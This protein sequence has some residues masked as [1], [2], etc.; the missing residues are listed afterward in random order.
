MKQKHLNTTIEEQVIRKSKFQ[1]KKI[2]D[3]VQ[4]NYKMFLPQLCEE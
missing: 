4:D 1:S 3:S 2:Q